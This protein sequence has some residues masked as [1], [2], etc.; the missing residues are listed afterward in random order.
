MAKRSTPS[1]QRRK[2]AGAPRVPRRRKASGV[3]QR[4]GSAPKRIG[5]R[6]AVLEALDPSERDELLGLEG[7][8]Y[9]IYAVM[10]PGP[11][12]RRYLELCDRGW[13]RLQP[14]LSGG[15][16]IATGRDSADPFGPRQVIPAD[17]WPYAILDYEKW[18]AKIG[19]VTIVEIEIATVATLFISK[20]FREVRLGSVNLQLHG[21]LFPLF[22]TLAEGAKQGRSLETLDDIRKKHYAPNADRRR[23]A[24]DI[25][26]IKRQ[27][28]SRGI[29]RDTVD[30]LLINVPD[31]GYRLN[32]PSAG[33]TIVDE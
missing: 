22:L 23:P 1:P 30:A 6:E 5:L 19:H 32:I 26:K 24:Q 11:K 4:P 27:M 20:K 25:F 28:E 2:V 10:T 13:A 18:T 15:G 12:G 17:R 31:K 7:E 16:L 8:A 21:N 3:S 33:I 29:D 14:R 9:M